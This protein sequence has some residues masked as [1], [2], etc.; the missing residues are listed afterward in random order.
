[1]AARRTT[2]VR[3]TTSPKERIR[4]GPAPLHAARR[5][6]AAERPRNPRTPA[7]GRTS[8]PR[9]A[10]ACSRLSSARSTACPWSR[11]SARDLVDEPDRPAPGQL[12]D[13]MRD[14]IRN[15]DSEAD[16]VRHSDPRQPRRRHSLEPERIGRSRARRRRRRGGPAAPR[17][18]RRVSRTP[19]CRCR[20]RPAVDIVALD[21]VRC[22]RPTP[23]SR[24]STHASRRRGSPISPYRL[25][26]SQVTFR[27]V[28]YDAEPAILG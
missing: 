20:S 11:A 10:G 8:G 24:T 3:P 2:L 5:A 7:K 9:T 17:S 15:E 14:R 16:H 19:L 27:Q 4:A 12:V 13:R 23:G 18:R 26:N 6:R 21:P 25:L 22:R 28:V 1:M